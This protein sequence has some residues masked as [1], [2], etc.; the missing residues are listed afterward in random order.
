MDIE[1]P[2]SS[3]I[4]RQVLGE[5]FRFEESRIMA[6]KLLQDLDVF[7]EPRNQ[8]IFEAVCHLHDAGGF[9]PKLLVEHLQQQRRL[10]GV[11]GMGALIELA[12]QTAAS[13]VMTRHHCEILIDR[14]KR[15]KWIRF[16]HQ[17]R[18]EA[19]TDDLQ[20]LTQQ[21]YQKMTDLN[22]A[23]PGNGLRGVQ[24]YLD[25]CLEQFQERLQRKC[26]GRPFKDIHTGTADLDHLTGGMNAGELW[27]IG[28]RPSEGKSLLAAQI[29]LHV[30]QSGPAA[31]FSLEMSGE[32][33]LGR[34]LS[35]HPNASDKEQARRLLKKADELGR[36]KLFIDDR[37]GLQISDIAARC[38][39]LKKE[40]GG[41]SLIVID[42]LQ[43]I[44]PPDFMAAKSAVAQITYITNQAKTLARR[45]Q[46]PVLLLSQLNRSCENEHRPPRL[47]DLRDSGSIEQDSDLVAFI[48]RP[49]EIER[50]ADGIREILVEK[51]RHGR[52]GKIQLVFN[53]E[54]LAFFGLSHHGDEEYPF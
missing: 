30:A 21:V 18:A 46:C 53:R 17:K 44:W 49:K 7:Y 24:D 6:K 16:F 14:W 31:F 29:A 12:E 27:T 23:D 40:Q 33:I 41:L 34:A 13:S 32:E 2:P 9:S 4:E 22:A 10:E 47:S 5:M 26:E 28:A 45:L 38:E 42:Y 48:H 25:S 36:L 51:N 20:E 35:T 37:G 50:G 11:G 52:T 54:Q 8:T 39:W 15:R 43:L 1:L 3:L 19:A